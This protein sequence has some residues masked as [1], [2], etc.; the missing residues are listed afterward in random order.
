MT[1]GRLLRFA[2]RTEHRAHTLRA[3]SAAYSMLVNLGRRA[4]GGDRKNVALS[5]TMRKCRP[6]SSPGLALREH[7]I[8][9]IVFLGKQRVMNRAHQ[10]QVIGRRFAAAGKRRVVV[11]QLEKAARLAA[12][13]G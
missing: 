2:C 10:P 4:T 6:S 8:S 5:R 13:A 3:E 12:P 7:E 1:R 9:S 11:M